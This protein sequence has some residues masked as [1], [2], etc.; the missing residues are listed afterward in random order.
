MCYRDSSKVWYIYYTLP[1]KNNDTIIVQN[2]RIIITYFR[3]ILLENSYL[4]KFFLSPCAGYLE[5]I[6]PWFKKQVFF[7][8][9]SFSE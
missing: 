1:V 2:A 8:E 4:P 6:Y 3:E 9:G 5:N 7:Q